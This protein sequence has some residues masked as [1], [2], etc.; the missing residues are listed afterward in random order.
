[1]IQVFTPLGRFLDVVRGADGHPMRFESAAGIAFDDSG[2]LYVAEVAADRVR[3]LRIERG[4]LPADTQTPTP[5]PSLSGGQARN[6]TICHIEWMPQYA[7]NIGQPLVEL[8]P[9]S[10]EQPLV[11]R[12]ETCLSCHD[13]SVVDSRRRVWDRHGHFTGVEPPDTMKVPEYLPLVEGRVACRTCHSAHTTGTP[14][15]NIAEAVFL[16]VP[17][18]A[19]ELCISC[20]GDKTRGPELGTHPTGGMPWAVPQELIRAGA[21]V[22]PNPRELTCQVCH[23]PHGSS[24]DH[25]LVMGVESNQL[26]L[27]CHEQMRPGMFR[28]GDHSE[29]PL[30][31]VVNAE[32]KTAIQR[33][34]T[35]LGPEDRLICLSCH[36]LHHGK[37]RRFM[38]AAELTDG[39][40]CLSCHSDKNS[41]V[42][43]RH[44]LRTNRPDERNRLGMTAESGGPCSSCHM[45]HRY[46]RAPEFDEADPSGHC[47]TCHQPGRVAAGAVPG[48][49]RHDGLV[50]C[51]QCHNPHT[52]GNGSFLPGRPVDVCSECHAEQAKLVGGAHDISVH[53]VGGWPDAAQAVNDP[54]LSCHRPHQDPTAGFFRVRP[55]ADTHGT[56]A[57]CI[58]CHR[59]AAW[60][61]SASI[62]AMHPLRGD[63]LKNPHGLPL[64]EDSGDA[65]SRIGCNTC[66]N[67]HAQASHLG[68]LLRT[69]D[70]ESASS[71]CLRC[72]TD[73]AHVRFTGHSEESLSHAG[74]DSVACG[75][76]HQM[77]G[78]PDSMLPGRLWPKSLLAGQF[79]DSLADSHG[80]DSHPAAGARAMKTVGDPFCTACHRVGGAAPAPAVATHPVVPLMQ[81]A[82][83][84]GPLPLFDADG[85]VS[86]S[87]SI[88]CRTCHVP[89]GQLEAGLSGEALSKMGETQQ[90][91]LRLQLRPF[92]TPNTCTSCHGADALRRFLYFHDA[93]RRSGELEDPARNRGVLRSR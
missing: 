19:S 48:H 31:P 55:A 72:H 71:L 41:V 66:H 37:G 20:H 88:T 46:A 14:T 6:C 91:A 86:A 32:Q 87:G 47:V 39:Q 93:R 26:C 59:E 21:K 30:R 28:E 44:D 70:G 64:V 25:L 69:A 4:P 36:R 1:V 12:S 54:C 49:S 43:T 84:A 79:G 5:R 7:E 89:H 50:R 65:A 53:A 92:N 61:G 74:L 67:P 81:V 3:K 17:N 83:M 22:G 40:M 77:H 78:L 63:P 82:G 51:E 58:G 57:V 45:F 76:C 56:D 24:N 27:S 2:H 34:E 85:Q 9:A 10:P 68:K 60:G 11:S 73:M 90:R 16:R 38:L 80:A 52:P 13:G 29:H 75:P 35:R 42:G 18:R 62:T 33:L 15:G 23:T 8:P